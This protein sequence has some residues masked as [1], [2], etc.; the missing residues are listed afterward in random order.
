MEEIYQIRSCIEI[1]MND[2]LSNILMND[3]LSNSYTIQHYLI[4]YS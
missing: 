3:R 2:R 4:I 1:L